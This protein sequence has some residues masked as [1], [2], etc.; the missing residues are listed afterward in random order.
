MKTTV[1]T[2]A[3]GWTLRNSQSLK[4]AGAMVC[5]A[6]IGVFLVSHK[7]TRSFAFAD[8]ADALNGVSSAHWRSTVAQYDSSGKQTFQEVDDN[9]ATLDPGEL[10]RT[11]VAL[12]GSKFVDTDAGTASY[13]PNTKVLT[14]LKIPAGTPIP[15]VKETVENLITVSKMDQISIVSPSPKG[16][17]QLELRVEGNDSSK[18]PSW[19][20]KSVNVG[21]KTMTQ[22]TRVITLPGGKTYLQTVVVDPSTKL[23]DNCQYAIKDASGKVTESGSNDHFTYNETPPSGT[24]VVNPP[25]GT[26]VRVVKPFLMMREITKDST[27]VTRDITK[28]LP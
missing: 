21:G 14:K 7:T 11:N 10:S 16:A 3:S 19:S 23:I 6:L 28:T 13:D 15:S 22:F 27:G 5:A 2:S 1:T 18:M 8:V 4:F 17:Q 26:K 9:W 24:F 20:S 12:P 25:P